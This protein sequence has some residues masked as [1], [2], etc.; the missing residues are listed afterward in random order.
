MPARLRMPRNLAETA[1]REGRRAWL[2][3][4]PGLVE[5]AGEEWSLT[6][7]E[8]FQPGGS[9][10]WV[11]PVRDAGGA[12]LVLKIVWPHP[13]AACEA[14]GLRAWA[15]Q[16]AVRLHAARDLAGA[17]ALLVERCRPG[18]ALSARP[19]AEQDPVIAALLRRLWI[20]P[21]RDHPFPSLRQMCRQWA[22]E[23]APGALDPLDPGLARA[24]LALWQELPDRTGNE[25]LLCTD[26]HAGNVLA[27]AREPWLVIDPKP[28]LGDPAYDL[29]QHLLN[30][31]GRL[32]SDPRGLARRLAGLA[33]LDPDLVL[34]WLFARCV[35]ESPGQPDLAEVARAIAP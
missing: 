4:L 25:V 26:L 2:A 11:A 16:G 5:Q 1:R 6:V 24:G 15:G 29:L 22:A 31:P 20:A 32:R 14:A 8:P 35:L 13:E 34:A 9:T 17:R 27:A 19:E 28:H 33:G 12:G 7:G 18:T 30:C 10:A 23:L 21:P 3:S